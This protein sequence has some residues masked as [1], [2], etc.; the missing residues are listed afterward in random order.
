LRDIFL[1]HDGCSGP[2]SDKLGQ[3]AIDLLR[4]AF[5]FDLKTG[6]RVPNPA[7]EA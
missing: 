4:A 5:D 2:L 6:I 3:E 7:A 1:G